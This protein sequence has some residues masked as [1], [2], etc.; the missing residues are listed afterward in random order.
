MHRSRR[1]VGEKREREQF[2]AR[3]MVFMVEEEYSIEE[4]TSSGL[5]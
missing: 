1:K 4:V 3:I 5:D 2:Q